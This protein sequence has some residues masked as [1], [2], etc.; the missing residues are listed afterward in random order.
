VIDYSHGPLAG[1]N[2]E[3]VMQVLEAGRAKIARQGIDADM[4]LIDFGGTAERVLSSRLRDSSYDCVVIGAGIREPR[5]RLALFEKVV[6]VVHRLAPQATIAFNTN[7]NDSSDA[8]LRWLR[9]RDGI[10]SFV[11]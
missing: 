7:P 1:F 11:E 6:N 10:G 9:P 5:D 2:A 8:V 4:C 3:G